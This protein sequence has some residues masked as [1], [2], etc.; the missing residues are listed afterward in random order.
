MTNSTG[1][2]PSTEHA[3]SVPT[4]ASEGGSVLDA[5]RARRE[6]LAED[7]TLNIAVPGYEELLFVQL[8]VIPSRQLQTIRDRAERSNSPDAETNA[9]ADLLINGCQDILARA[10]ADDDLAPIDDREATTI[11]KRL[12]EL[13]KLDDSSARATLV[14]LFRAAPSPDLA[15]GVAAG[16]YVQWMRSGNQEID[17]TLLGES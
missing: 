10:N 16:E 3:N 14:D 15:I 8:T 11:G 6:Q 9:N 2:T 7:H 4:A 17:E 12:A 1:E 5:L 13:L